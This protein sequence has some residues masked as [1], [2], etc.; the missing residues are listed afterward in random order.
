MAE[1]LSPTQLVEILRNEQRA[2]WQR[3]ER[4][5]AEAYLERH[6]ALQADA[7][8][9]LQLVYQEVLLREESGERPQLAEYVQRFPQF[10][11][12]LGPLFEVHR[13]LESGSLQESKGT[14]PSR[15]TTPPESPRLGNVDWPSV[16]GYEI[17]E[18]LG[19][20]GMGIVYKARQEGLNRV[21]ALKMIVSGAHADKEEV[22]RFR[23]EAQA[24]A[25]L[26]H[27]HIVQIYEVD[28]HEGIP[29]FALEF[30][31]GGSL[32]HKLAG[33]PQPA[34]GAAQLL[35]TLA[36]AVHYAHQRGL[37]HR[38]LKPANVLL[39]ADGIPKIAD[40]GLAKRVANAGWS[41]E[42]PGLTQ[43]GAIVGTPTYM[44]PEQA[45]GKTKAIGGAA[46]VYA[47][48]AILYEA[49]TGRPP[50]LGETALDT[51][52]QVRSQE[53]VPLRR[54]QPKVPRDLETVCLK[55]LQKEP[56]QRYAS[57]EA[58]AEDLRCFWEGKPI[59]ARSIRI[60]ERGLKWVRRR[61]AVAALL[62][63]VAA[64]LVTVIATLAVGFVAV[65]QEKNRTEAARQRARKALDAMSSQV[66]EDWLARQ[67]QLSPEQKAFLG[68]A[69]AYYEE[70]A[71]ESG[72][73]PEVRGDVAGAYV[74][75]GLIRHKLRQHAEAKAALYRAGDLYA[76]LVADFPAVPEYR[77]GLAQSHNNLGI[78][79]SDLG[80]Y[81]EAEAAFREAVQLWQEQVHELPAVPQ[82]RHDLA[83]SYNNL[84]VLLRDLGRHAK[85]ETV[86]RDAVELQ[87]QLA[88]DSPAVPQY[89]HDLAVSHY[90][91]GNVLYDLGQRVE[92][93]E[94]AFREAVKLQQQ[95]V[96]DSPAVP[97]YRQNLAQSHNSLGILLRDRGQRTEAES[98]FR[99][100]VKLRQQLA[101]DFPSVGAYR[102]DLAQSY[103]SLGI[104]LYGL[105]QREDAEAAFRNMVKI[106]EQLAH[107]FPHVPAYREELAGSYNNLGGLLREL[108]RHTEAEA[109][110]RE[111]V[112]IQQQ[113]VHDS[114]SVP[115]LRNELASSLV[116]LADLARDQHR[117]AEARQLLEQ[118]RS[119]HQAALQAIPQ[120]PPYRRSFRTNLATLAPILAALSDHAAAA[121]TAE[122]MARLGWNPAADS[123]NA[124]CALALCVPC[125]E[126]DAKLAAAERQKQ[127]RAYA[128]RALE[129]LRQ[130]I[131]KG[132]R[133]VAHLKKDPDLDP[134]RPREEFQK[135]LAE[136]ERKIK[137]KA[138]PK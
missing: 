121:A 94:S 105:G 33:T 34:R 135:L 132:Y 84:G 25:Q 80:Q 43:S 118:A 23:A 120:H 9:A 95:L 134:L 4:I 111:A 18:R 73:T 69:L 7:A 100:A 91:L 83:Q 30:V 114:P 130:A 21:V 72:D 82:Y 3:G 24:Q 136:L 106:E 115:D 87:Q 101:H 128:D 10:A 125:A 40:F 47:L 13:A 127:A 85:A 52:H 70:F 66:I 110:L 53:P 48:G 65:K 36:R 76:K 63:G 129:L 49:L 20:G 93:A 122:E 96:H 62:A 112:K 98:A 17:L 35:E 6:P 37:I 103:N 124:A 81:V 68:T 28:E 46:D 26:Q 97:Q 99:E 78:L 32:A 12:Q 67:T 11:S 22:A 56:R 55:C 57:A 27:P 64:L 79:L 131:A 133:D 116:G 14:D 59:Q 104:L 8:C 31:A 77:H 90:N 86:F 108:G 41:P 88:D 102:H 61:P 137:E 92:E 113:L 54:L 71:A 2:G 109:T 58:L 38:D 126:K 29:Y 119:H 74:R 5:L 89:R 39:T 60:W 16:T 107:D 42:Q 19:R 123:Y 51:L 1:H 75:V 117:Y 50:F 138:N 15:H 45:T 44:A